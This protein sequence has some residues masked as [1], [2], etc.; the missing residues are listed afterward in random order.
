MGI[1]TLGSIPFKVD[2]DVLFKRLHIDKDSEEAEEVINLADAASRIAKP[3]VL[4]MESTV[5]EKGDDYVVIDNIRFNSRVLRVNLDSAYR[6]FPYVCT[7]GT[8][9]EEWADSLQD[10]LERYWAE[11]IMKMAL[12]KAIEAFNNHLKDNFHPGHTSSMNP[13]SLEDW[14]ISQQRQLFRILGNPKQY[15]GVELT[16]SYL[17][18]PMKSVSGIRFPTESSFENCQLC[19]REN[20]PGRRAPYD[21]L[22]YAQKYA[23]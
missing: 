16:E 15:I 23:K 20:C 17:M 21:R 8:E 12:D 14:P 19:S 7:C 22:L 9:L 4:Y 1:I 6:V 10:M 3:K 11:E 2:I 18:M 5:N 13:G